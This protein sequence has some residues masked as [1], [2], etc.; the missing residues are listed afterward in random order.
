MCLVSYGPLGLWCQNTDVPFR[1]GC[2]VT[3][4]HVVEPI[5]TGS[6]RLII[7]VRDIGQYDS[8]ASKSPVIHRIQ[9]DSPY[10]TSSSITIRTLFSLTF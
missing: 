5:F 7:L 10:S 9:L 6:Y 3:L 4:F 8:T 2:I 1:F